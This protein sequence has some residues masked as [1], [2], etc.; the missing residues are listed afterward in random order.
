M[1]RIEPG[2]HGALRAAARDYGLSLN[3][4]CRR[5]LAA[6]TGGG[7]MGDAAHAVRRAAVLF[8]DDLVAVAA[9]DGARL[10]VALAKAAVSEH[11]GR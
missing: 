7:E 1:L 3:D 10:V 2:L 5:K 8:G 9:F 6:P 4:Y 11:D